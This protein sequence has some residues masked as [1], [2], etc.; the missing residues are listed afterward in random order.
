MKKYVFVAVALVLGVVGVARATDLGVAAS[1]GV[2]LDQQCVQQVQSVIQPQAYTA[3]S[4]LRIVERVVQPQVYQHVQT[5]V[6]APVQA[7]AV[8]RQYVASPVIAQKVIA[9]QYVRSNLV[10]A[11][12]LQQQY[13]QSAAIV[14]GGYGSSNI[15]AV[16]SGGGGLGSRL[17]SR[18]G[19]R[20]VT[21]SFSR[22]VTKSR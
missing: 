20:T 2:C 1:T 11:P 15:S 5:V 7:V 16:R 14:G 6:A 8:Q 13:T 12:V 17:F 18:G 22:S 10:A 9:Q 4:N 19:G 3:A 21:R